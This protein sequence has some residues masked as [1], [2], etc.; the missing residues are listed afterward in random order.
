MDCAYDVTL[1]LLDGTRRVAERSWRLDNANPQLV[2]LSVAY[3]CDD[4]GGVTAGLRIVGDGP[5]GGAEADL[6]WDGEPATPTG[7]RDFPARLVSTTCGSTGP[8]PDPYRTS[9]LAYSTG[10]KGVFRPHQSYV[11][12]ADRATDGVDGEL[13]GRDLRRDGTFAMPTWLDYDQPFRSLVSGL[14]GWRLASEVT[15]YGANG[16]PTEQRD[17]IGVYAA[18]VYGYGD[19]LPVGVAANARESEIAVAD[20]EQ[21]DR[22][23]DCLAATN[24]SLA[25][26]ADAPVEYTETYNVVAPVGAGAGAVVLDRT[27]DHGAGIPT[28]ATLHLRDRDGNA[29]LRDWRVGGLEPVDRGDV[30]GLPAGLA[31]QA[32]TFTRLRGEPSSA[33]CEPLPAAAGGYY[34]EVTLHYTR[35]PSASSTAGVAQVSG[36]EAHTGTHSLRVTGPW[37][38]EQERLRLRAGAAYVLSGWVR[39]AA[40]AAAAEPLARYVDL[41]AGARVTRSRFAAVAVEGW[42]RFEVE[43]AATGAPLALALD[44]PHG[45]AYYDDVRVHP[46]DASFQSYVYALDDYRLLATLDE[47]NYA[48]V[49]RYDAQGVLTGTLK[50]T[51]RGLKTIQETRAHTRVTAQQ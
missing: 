41:P 22:D 33:A 25:N 1:Y 20:F 50:E 19:F 30:A 12:V 42:R 32:T 24:F 18:S 34:G 3:D 17:A 45:R 46:V 43:F 15:R 14:G 8:A 21:V 28:Y 9:R 6:E 16:E 10:Q 48:T 39:D 37:R 26:D 36:L 29:Y 23:G 5:C 40:D 27:A 13:T 7:G 35:A 31:P 44:A 38:A 47:N 49:Y 51:E 11:Y 2:N 4:C